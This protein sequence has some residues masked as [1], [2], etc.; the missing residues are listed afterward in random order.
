MMS[1]RERVLW[2]LVF[3]CIALTP[4]P[5][6][7]QDAPGTDLTPRQLMILAVERALAAQGLSVESGSV[8]SGYFVTAPAPLDSARLSAV[9]RPAAALTSGG[10]S[11]GDY[12][13]SMRLSIR[14]DGWLGGGHK[15]DIRAWP[16][17][18]ASPT[19]PGPE[20]AALASNGTL[21]QEFMRA[22]GAEVDRVAH[23]FPPEPAEPSGAEAA[24]AQ[25]PAVPAGAGR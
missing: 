19:G 6:A 20:G 8:A 15:V 21:E 4:W 5:S 1:Q 24:P 12:R 22:I 18:A 16:A 25:S 11:R 10:W 2:G 13:L 23:L 14:Q 17:D 7:A 9:A 3:G